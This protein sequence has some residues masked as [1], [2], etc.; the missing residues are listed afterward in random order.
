MR[1]KR[2]GLPQK[3]QLNKHTNRTL[4]TGSLWKMDTMTNTLDIREL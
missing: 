3:P 4:D 2:D 1:Q